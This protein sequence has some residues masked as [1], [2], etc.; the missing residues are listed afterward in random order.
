MEKTS[1]QGPTRYQF[2]KEGTWIRPTLFGLVGWANNPSKREVLAENL[3][4]SI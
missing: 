2:V 1:F 4:T 3:Y